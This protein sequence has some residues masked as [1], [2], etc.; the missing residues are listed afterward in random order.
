MQ[1][2][3]FFT[4]KSKPCTFFE[5]EINSLVEYCRMTIEQ[6]RTNINHANVKNFAGERLMERLSSLYDDLLNHRRSVHR[7]LA[8]NCFINAEISKLNMELICCEIDLEINQTDINQAETNPVQSAL[9]LRREMQ[10]NLIHIKAS[11]S[12]RIKLLEARPDESGQKQAAN[13]IDALKDLLNDDK[14]RSKPAFFQ[15][16]RDNITGIDPKYAK[17][18]KLRKLYNYNE[19]F[20]KPFFADYILGSAEVKDL[21]K[22]LSDLTL[23]NSARKANQIINLHRRMNPEFNTVESDLTKEFSKISCNTSGQRAARAQPGGSA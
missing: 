12:E 9:Q 18:N 16:I 22:I 21:C 5:R 4:G 15:Q 1:S 8:M 23:E 11:I 6:S 17:F 3:P 19:V 14:L 7:A 20:F 10:V 13:F 2:H